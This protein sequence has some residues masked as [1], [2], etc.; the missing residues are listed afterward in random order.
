MSICIIY[1]MFYN[2]LQLA[3]QLLLFC[4]LFDSS[5]DY[6][7]SDES[8]SS[9]SIK[10]CVY[11]YFPTIRYQIPYVICITISKLQSAPYIYFIEFVIVS[12]ICAISNKVLLSPV[13]RIFYYGEYH[14][15]RD[16]KNKW[17][18]TFE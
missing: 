17:N 2:T 14:S 6:T 11:I 18:R 16:N 1:N 12:L 9:Y 4:F 7:Y 8:N 5:D 15:C 10:D 13:I 3:G